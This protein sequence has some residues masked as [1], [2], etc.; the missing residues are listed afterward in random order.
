[1]QKTT[2]LPS[3][4]LDDQTNHRDKGKDGRSIQA[5]LLDLD[6]LVL[7]QT[8]LGILNLD[9]LALLDDQLVELLVSLVPLIILLLALLAG[10]RGD[11]DDGSGALGAAGGT[12]LGARRKEDVGDVVVLAEDGDVADDVHGADVGGE[13]D[14]GGSGGLGCGRVRGCGFADGLDD[15]FDTTLEALLLCGCGWMC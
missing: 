6:L 4:T 7:D 3:G 12:Q 11:H 13:D 8:R 9:V 10:G 2:G 14:N 1:V 5:L 15:F